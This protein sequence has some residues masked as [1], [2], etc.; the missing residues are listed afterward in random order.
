MLS[1]CYQNNQKILTNEEHFY[2]LK[3]TK[4]Q[5]AL[6]K[7]TVQTEQAREFLE[8]RVTHVTVEM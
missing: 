5:F 3:Y 6:H 4:K 7:T 2:R 1:K 8:S